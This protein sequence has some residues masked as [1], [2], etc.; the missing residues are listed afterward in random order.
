M[1]IQNT[2]HLRGHLG[3]LCNLL[4]LNL[5]LCVVKNMV[6]KIWTFVC[7][8][9]IWVHIFTVSKFKWWKKHFNIQL[10]GLWRRYKNRTC[11][12]GAER[13]ARARAVNTAPAHRGSMTEFSRGF[14]S[15]LLYH[16]SLW[17]SLPKPRP[18]ARALFCIFCVF[19]WTQFWSFLP[20]YFISF[21]ALR[22]RSV[23]LWTWL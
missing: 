18:L 1:T 12:S 3:S 4:H 16:R 13:C 14:D 10:Y 6:N 7:G 8:E 17:V 21:L 5:F 23:Y 20:S 19:H 15:P 11:E 22:L 9:I 2:R